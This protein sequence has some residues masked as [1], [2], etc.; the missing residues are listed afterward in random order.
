MLADLLYQLIPNQGYEQSCIPEVKLF[1]ADAP[2]GRVPMVYEPCICIVAQGHKI[3]YI[4][5]ESF[6]Y[7][8]D[9][10]L[11]TSVHAPFS[12]ESFATAE[13]PLLG[14]SIKISPATLQDL[15]SQLPDVLS[16]EDLPRIT[17]AAGMDQYMKDAVTRLARCLGDDCE[18][19]ILGPGIIREILY[20]AL[21]GEQATSLVALA[22]RS[23]KF[24]QVA[25]AIDVIHRDYAEVL[26]VDH[27]AAQ[28]EMS[29]STFHRA[30]KKMCA[31]SPL[32]YIKKIR[33]NKARELIVEQGTRI[34]IAAQH[35][36]Y[37]S[38][39]Q[40]SREFKRHFGQSPATLTERA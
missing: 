38:P 21:R 35:V 37:E 14:L 19:R 7:D 27:L 26:D 10:Y 28:A 1:R 33:L 22:T 3:G 25:K 11:V 16:Q 4:N 6:R 12:C 13:E 36:G 30:F 20:W 15:V 24:A 2:T 18:A 8:P 29:P 5:E 34:H 31:E 32:Q 17:G 9:H 23:G 40:F 39:S